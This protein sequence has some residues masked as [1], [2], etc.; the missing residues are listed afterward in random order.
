VVW[1]GGAKGWRNATSGQVTGTISVVALSFIVHEPS[2]IMEVV[3]D[4][5]RASRRLM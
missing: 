4:R 2:G 5:S 1:C 3:S